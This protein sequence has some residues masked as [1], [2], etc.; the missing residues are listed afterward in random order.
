MSQELRD[1]LRKTHQ[2]FIQFRDVIDWEND[3]KFDHASGGQEG[4]DENGMV[5]DPET[6]WRMSSDSGRMR[7][8]DRGIYAGG[9]GPSPISLEKLRKIPGFENVVVASP[10]GGMNLF[11]LMHEMVVTDLTMKVPVCDNLFTVGSK[12]DILGIQEG[13]NNGMLCGYNINRHLQ[14]KEMI[15]I[16]RTTVTGDLFAS[17]QE[18]LLTP[19]GPTRLLGGHAGDYLVRC[20]EMGWF[21]DTPENANKRIAD[22]GLTNIFA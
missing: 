2:I 4:S 12:A 1:Q 16:P 10:V 7:L 19:G 14:G 3:P 20:K 9:A 8:L 5:T 21:P 11:S 18:H 22:A 6:S 13:I 15:I 17:S